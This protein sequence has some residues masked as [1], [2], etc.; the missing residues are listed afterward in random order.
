M[1][2]GPSSSSSERTITSSN[3]HAV[4]HGRTHAPSRDRSNQRSLYDA[5]SSGVSHLMHSKVFQEISSILGSLGSLSP[6]SIEPGSSNPSY[7][8]LNDQVHNALH[9][10]GRLLTDQTEYDRECQQLLEAIKAEQV[11]IGILQEQDERQNTHTSARKAKIIDALEEAQG[12]V[13]ETARLT[14][15]HLKHSS[16]IP[17]D[18]PPPLAPPSTC[19]I[20][21]TKRT[22]DHL[23]F[24]S[25]NQLS[26]H[27][28]FQLQSEKREQDRA[29][30]NYGTE[31]RYLSMKDG[32]PPSSTAVTTGF[33]NDRAN[34]KTV[35]LA[36]SHAKDARA[37][38]IASQSQLHSFNTIVQQ[39]HDEMASCTSKRVDLTARRTEIGARSHSLLSAA[40]KATHRN[41][42]DKTIERESAST[43]AA[44]QSEHKQKAESLALDLSEFQERLASIRNIENKLH[45]Q[46]NSLERKVVGIS[47]QCERSWKQSRANNHSSSTEEINELARKT[48]EAKR[49]L[50]NLQNSIRANTL[51]QKQFIQAHEKAWSSQREEMAE[52]RKALDEAKALFA[53]AKSTRVESGAEVRAAANEHLCQVVEARRLEAERNDILLDQCKTIDS[54]T[55]GIREAHEDVL[56]TESA[57]K[58]LSGSLAGLERSK[59]SFARGQKHGLLAFVEEKVS[60]EK[61]DTEALKNQMERNERE[62]KSTDLEHELTRDTVTQAN[63]YSQ[64]RAQQNAMPHG[65]APSDLSELQRSLEEVQREQERCFGLGAVAK[66]AMLSISERDLER[67]IGRQEAAKQQQNVVKAIGNQIDQDH[68][69]HIA[70]LR[71]RDNEVTEDHSRALQYAREQDQKVASVVSHVAHDHERHIQYLHDKE[72]G[73]SEDRN[74]RLEYSKEQDHKIAEVGKQINSDHDK[75]IQHIKNR[76]EEV[77]SVTNEIARE[78]KHKA[79]QGIKGLRKSQTASMANLPGNS[80]RTTT[81]IPIPSISLNT[82]EREEAQKEHDASRVDGLI[83]DSCEVGIDTFTQLCMVAKLTNLGTSAVAVTGGLMEGSRKLDMEMHKINEGTSNF[84]NALKEGVEGFCKGASTEMAGAIFGSTVSSTPLNALEPLVENIGK[85]FYKRASEKEAPSAEKSCDNVII[86]TTFDATLPK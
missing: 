57:V 2:R 20:E 33:K 23:S 56:S 38:L 77:C 68:E 37:N 86:G 43:L 65:G 15:G 80:I 22:E 79:D 16:S 46:K 63:A 8:S 53:G 24:S 75:H 50:N 73:I 30:S 17:L 41:L 60:Q 81:G 36:Q 51:Q 59:F 49:E 76:D 27:L 82:K 69:K 26:R 62:D 78:P 58:E 64:I 13:S 67:A 55:K 61:Q 72:R 40:E 45:E 4:T 6:S 1:I 34:Q 74:K 47:Q 71:D 29:T 70:Y 25:N 5:I 9:E 10:D 12:L 32:D 28:E 52:T 54:A 84:N 44:R 19:H 66:H 48:F 83:Q 11:R 39:Y 3:G 31:Y 85:E 35:G 21:D 18:V 14:S 7:Q 42:H